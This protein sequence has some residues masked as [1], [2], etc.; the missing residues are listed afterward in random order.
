MLSIYS[1]DLIFKGCS[2]SYAD[3][4]V[5]HTVEDGKKQFKFRWIY[6]DL[7]S[8]N[9]DI[10][11]QRYGSSS[12]LAEISLQTANFM[13]ECEDI[14]RYEDDEY[15]VHSVSGSKSEGFDV[16]CDLNLQD[17]CGELKT[18]YTLTNSTLS[19]A[20]RSLLENYNR[21]QSERRRQ[22]PY[23]E[24][25]KNK[26]W[27]LGECNVTKRRSISLA[28]V[29]PLQIIEKL[30]AAYMVEPVYDTINGVISFYDRVGEDKGVFFYRGLNLKQMQKITDSY[31]LYT[32]ISCFGK[33]GLSCGTVTNYTYTDVPK[34]YVWTDENYTSSSAMLEDA[35][36]L[37]ADLCHPIVSYSIQVSDLQSM[38]PDQYPSFGFDC[39][40]TI[41]IMDDDSDTYDIQRI[42]KMTTYP[43]SPEKNTVELANCM[44]TFEQMQAKLKSAAD[45]SSSVIS[46]DG[47]I[48]Y[49]KIRGLSNS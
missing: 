9:M 18:E 5:T 42:V 43:F 36:A 49:T 3:P 27:S 32:K 21:G 30:C 48:S 37:L 13:I 1:K 38:Y 39:G 12:T 33:D 41:T 23:S 45:V 14:I 24:I 17:L 29:T 6:T 22:S 44:L 28:N 25:A 16:V 19:S 47:K 8:E 20:V 4:V 15:I 34:L 7:L 40:D 35:A 26:Y 46:S 2:W 11:C 10:G 31:D